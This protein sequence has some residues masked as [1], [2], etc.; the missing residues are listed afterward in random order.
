MEIRTFYVSFTEQSGRNPPTM[1][2]RAQ[3]VKIRKG[4]LHLMIGR[5]GHEMP[6]FVANMNEISELEDVTHDQEYHADEAN[7]LGYTMAP[8]GY[9]AF[10]TRPPG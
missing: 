4:R 3:F 5:E 8:D 1:L 7:G 2:L 9:T 10:E 6:A